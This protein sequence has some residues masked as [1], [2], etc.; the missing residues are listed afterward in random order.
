M[1]LSC[2]G[3]TKA[4]PV[5]PRYKSVDTQPFCRRPLHHSVAIS[6]AKS[7]FHPHPLAMFR[8]LSHAQNCV[9]GFGS[10]PFSFCCKVPGG[11]F[12]QSSICIRSFGH[13]RYP[14]HVGRVRLCAKPAAP[15]INASKSTDLSTLSKSNSNSS[16]QP[17]ALDILRSRGLFD[18]ATADDEVLQP[19][20]SS[21]VG[22]YMGF[23]PTADSLHL[24]NLLAIIALAWFQRQGH[25]IVAVVGGATGKV[26]DPSG[27]NLERPVLSK[28]T[29]R[30]NLIGI[31]ANLRQVLD[32]C[33]ENTTESGGTPGS[34]TVVN[35][36]DWIGQ[37]TFLDFLRDVG[38]H[39]RV[40]SMLN[41][42]SVR[43]RLGSEDGMSFTEFA[44][45][46]LQAY[47]FMHLNEHHGV[48]F[49]LGGSDQWGNITAGTELTRKLRGQTVHGITIPLL[50]TSDGR[51]FG[52][53]E[54]GAVW[55]T[56]EKLSPYEFYQFLFKTTDDD[57]ITFLKRLT[58]LSLD[59]VAN[60]E[61]SMKSTDYEANTAQKRLAEEV[62]RIVH[63]EEGL[64]AAIA[65]TAAAA[66]GSKAVLNA[67]IL[68][69]IAGDMPNVWLRHGELIGSC[70]VDVMV[71]SD[72]QKSKGEARRLIKNGGAYLNNQK[73]TDAS[74]II[75]D[76]ELI[77]GRFL[78]LSA[79]KK[80]KLLVRVQK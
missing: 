4:C 20:L 51:K 47:D 6:Y 24:G 64:E 44:Y 26:G 13:S 55:L 61:K 10:P 65:A 78:L 19:L 57:V 74:I 31:E 16:T 52:K 60:I 80:N 15:P 7:D 8:H 25:S 69:S 72:L 77:D 30:H 63:G 29:I 34:L 67:E 53:S 54:K 38:K 41:K 66:P 58:F 1:R 27:K 43:S 45:Q 37:M 14:S 48:S 40:S 28:E 68:E 56:P 21:P 32:R 35:N 12:F 36:H 70:I 39:A 3:A 76:S 75:R 79:G 2:F 11:A 17:T 9:P 71:R 49:Q 18:A 62:T 73:I 46:L 33:A 42:D 50:T 22:V 59:E 5:R 23:D